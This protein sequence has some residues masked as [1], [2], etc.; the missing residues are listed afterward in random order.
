MAGITV[1]HLSF[2]YPQET[3]PALRDVSF[4]VEEGEFLTVIGPSGG[5]KSTLLRALKP[6][7]TPHGSFTGD[8]SFF[9]EPLSA[10]DAR[11]QAAEI[12]FVLQKPDEQIVTDR[13]W[14]ELAF[15]MES[16][17]FATPVIRRRVAEMA[18]FFGIEEWFSRPVE[19]LS[20]GQK[21]LLNLAS[22]MALQPRVLLLDEP[23]SQLDPI[24]AAD[25]LNAV[26]RI[27]RELG[28]TVILSEHRLEE[29]LPLCDRVLALEQT[30]LSHGTPQEV[31]RTLRA[32]DSPVYFSMPT[33]VRVSGSVGADEC[34]VTVTEGR[35][36]L[37]RYAASHPLADVP[38]RRLR[39][40]GEELLGLKDVWFRYEK[41]G[42][43]V[44]QGLSCSFARGQLTALLGGNGSGKTTTLSL[45]AGLR[46]P[47]R[48]KRF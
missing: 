44:L 39:L 2:T 18:S 20:G 35:Q 46:R 27:R 40:A 38:P 3:V 12:G 4:S 30:V 17:G 28:T 26:A 34:P 37:A 48:G 21:Q 6:A 29:A 14:H 47:L 45:L 13:V 10:L 8:I 5:G 7:L 25:F 19:A 1:S 43:D 16:L 33:P 15:G 41:D 23:T 22:V 36:W 24:A 11:R 9:G 31:S 32:A 42:E